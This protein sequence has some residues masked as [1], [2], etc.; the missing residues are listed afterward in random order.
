MIF[1]NKRAQLTLFVIV[2]III[3]T[4]LVIGLIY[5]KQSTQG[6]PEEDIQGY[7]QKCIND[8]VKSSEA[9]LLENNG[10]MNLSNNYL[11]YYG[12]KVP[13]LCKATEFYVPC[14]NQEPMYIG[15]LK[16]EIKSDIEKKSQVCFSDLKYLLQKKGYNVESLC[17][18]A[19][20][21]R[22]GRI[23]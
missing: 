22:I 15:H 8:G 12:Q 18:P 11:V 19:L 3:I 10:Y 9:K 5:F 23:S 17:S 16:N 6:S 4:A 21:A 1:E 14:V 13:Y 2:A 7:I 20:V